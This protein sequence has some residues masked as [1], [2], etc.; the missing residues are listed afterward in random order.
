MDEFRKGF[1]SQALEGGLSEKEAAHL[2][3]FAE[4]HPETSEVFKELGVDSTPAQAPEAAPGE[5][6][7]LKHVDEQ[8]KV[9]QELMA[10]KQQLGI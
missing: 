2:W 6:D 7:L 1:I 9:H 8:H 10:I 3:K 5:A 4:E